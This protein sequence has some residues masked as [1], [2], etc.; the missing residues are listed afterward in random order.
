LTRPPYLKQQFQGKLDVSGQI[1]ASAANHP[2]VRGAQ[3]VG[4]LTKVRVVENVEQF[5]AEL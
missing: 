2:E 3:G 5:G 4:W 1:I